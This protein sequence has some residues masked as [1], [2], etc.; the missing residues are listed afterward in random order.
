MRSL[1]GSHDEVT[2]CPVG[3][4]PKGARRTH[5]YDLRRP[6]TALSST[7]RPGSSSRV[8]YSTSSLL[9]LPRGNRRPWMFFLALRA[10]STVSNCKHG[11]GV[12]AGAQNVRAISER[13]ERICINREGRR[14]KSG[15][16]LLLEASSK[17]HAVT[18]EWRNSE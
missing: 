8:T 12:I 2:Y 10:I 3:Y 15:V 7:L 9:G 13:D 16:Q 11:V 18:N 6:F 17:E 4:P 1:W 5:T 14:W